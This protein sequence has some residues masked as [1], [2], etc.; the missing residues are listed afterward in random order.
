MI[1]NIHEVDNLEFLHKA[2]NN[3]YDLIVIDPP[4]KTYKKKVKWEKK[5]MDRHNY[6]FHWMFGRVREMHRILTN[7]GSVLFICNQENAHQSREIFN[8]IFGEKNCLNEIIWI[9]S[10]NCI[11]K[12]NWSHTY[13][14]ILWYVKDI[15][16]YIY[17]SVLS[18]NYKTKMVRYKC[19]KKAFKLQKPTD[20]WYDLNDTEEE[21]NVYKRMIRVH[22]KP[23]SKILDCF[24]GNGILGMAANQLAQQEKFKGMVDLV[25][26]S[27]NA[28]HYALRKLTQMKAENLY[29]NGLKF[30]DQHLIYNHVMRP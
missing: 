8:I 18:D 7:K 28:C 1:T 25:D 13:K 14:T 22:A 24:S 21:P 4:K 29:F 6:Y 12:N 20:I 10:T 9:N 23:D 15:N 3:T 19:G 2:N 16:N 27:K 26:S 30:D 17:K 5:Y 11:N